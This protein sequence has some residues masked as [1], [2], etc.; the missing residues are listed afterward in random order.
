MLLRREAAIDAI[1]DP[2]LIPSDAVLE[3]ENENWK[4]WE[5]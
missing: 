3:E 5:K 4:K 1:F 2:Q